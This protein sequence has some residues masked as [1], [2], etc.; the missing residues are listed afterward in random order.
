M[1][2][3]Y[4][5]IYIV[6]GV[7]FLS[8]CKKFVEIDTPRNFVS[9]DVMF[10]D[11][12][13]ASTAIL[14]MYSLIMGKSITPGFGCGT[15]T[16]YASQSAD[17]LI[18]FSSADPTFYQNTLVPDNSSNRIMWTEAYSYIYQANICIEGLEKSTTIPAI[19]K[20]QFLAE[21]KLVRAFLY[22]YLVNLYGDVPFVTSSNWSQT[23]GHGRTPVATIYETIINDL[24]VAQNDLPAK[25]PAAGKIRPVKQA[26]TALLARVY[27]YTR[28]WDKA[29][30]A[31]NAV[32]TSGMYPALPA[33]ASA[34]L[35][36]NDEAIW[37]LAPINT[38]YNTLEGYQLL[39]GSTPTYYFQ[40]P[41]ATAFE[42]GDLRYTNWVKSMVY[43][44]VTY[45]Y[46][47]KYKVR[48]SSTVTENYTMLRLAEQYLIRAEALNNQK[49]V[50]LAIND[51]NVI[52][53]RAGLTPLPKTLT[54]DECTAAVE[55]ERRVELFCEWGHRW[56]DL[57]RTGRADAVLSPIKPK[58]KPTAIWWPI[59]LTERVAD[60][61]LGQN[62]GYE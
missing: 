7:L 26:A 45:Y 33:P 28:Q 34:F 49:K 48:T 61:S 56:L 3:K 25:Y 29:E 1:N 51:L 19:T 30:A 58:W 44:G 2:K 39:P 32:I 47:Y 10:I 55:Q 22:F 52:R 4:F 37:Q 17:E 14:G 36:N 12:A 38:T 41:L 59:P 24:L 43:Q 5:I 16:L 9:T 60:P 20:S 11:S 15:V 35:K 18:S 42:P 13:S 50:E 8:S 23:Y 6:A 21:A 54:Q 40:T 27:L 53:Q 62:D 46:T 31:A 57:K